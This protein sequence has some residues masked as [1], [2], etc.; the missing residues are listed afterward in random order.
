MYSYALPGDKSRDMMRELGLHCFTSLQGCVRALKAMVDY[1]AFQR[2]RAGRAAP[3]RTANDM[4]EAARKL[5][6]RP[7]NV[8]CEYEAKALLA[9]YGVR[10]A[11]EALARTADEAAANAEQAG[12]ETNAGA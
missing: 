9:A 2:A 12:Q 7:N 4:P 3:V 8:L 1:A 5:L 10:I 6:S 11:D